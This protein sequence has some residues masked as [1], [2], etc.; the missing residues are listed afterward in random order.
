MFKGLW[1]FKLEDLGSLSEIEEET[2]RLQCIATI[3]PSTTLV[4]SGERVEKERKNSSLILYPQTAVPTIR[5]IS[6]PR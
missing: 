1:I 2:A 6:E 3:I 5:A 4:L